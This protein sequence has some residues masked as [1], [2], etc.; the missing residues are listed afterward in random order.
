MPLSFFLT[1]W[2]T[3]HPLSNTLTFSQSQSQPAPIASYLYLGLVYLN[4]PRSPV[5]LVHFQHSNDRPLLTPLS[6]SQRIVFTTN[7][8]L[9]LVSHTFYPRLSL[10]ISLS[11]IISPQTPSTCKADYR[12]SRAEAA[13]VEIINY[14]P[15]SSCCWGNH[16]I[17]FYQLYSTSINTGSRV[18]RRFSLRA[19]S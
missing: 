14:P 6:K 10:Y 18:L 13:L 4:I 17:F 5:F 3:S 2:P 1:L 7:K 15:K 19:R 9:R 12:E 8:P 11:S 16:C